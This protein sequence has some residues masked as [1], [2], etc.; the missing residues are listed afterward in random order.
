MT[1]L[2]E[3]Q[4]RKSKPVSR[5]RQIFIIVSAILLLWMAAAFLLLSY[6]I[7]G[8]APY[9]GFSQTATI[10]TTFN[11]EIRRLITQTPEAAIRR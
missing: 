6:A 3:K 10:V 2:P 11:P 8:S 5:L 1:T 9:P 7:L 4:K